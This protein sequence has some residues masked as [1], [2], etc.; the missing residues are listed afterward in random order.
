MGS[1]SISREK[2]RGGNI[3]SPPPKSRSEKKIR[4]PFEPETKP[5]IERRI[6]RGWLQEVNVI[7]PDGHLPILVWQ[8]DLLAIEDVE[9][10][11]HEV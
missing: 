8:S 5:H 2:T 4:L 11:G 6:E 3:W 10:V 7:N 1:L 9:E